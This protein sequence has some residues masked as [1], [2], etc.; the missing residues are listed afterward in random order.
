MTFGR[1]HVAYPLFH[2]KGSLGE[3]NTR[4]RLGN[5]ALIENDPVYGYIAL[6]ATESTA[7]TGS[8]INGPRNLAVVRVNKNDNSLDPALP[9]TLTVVSKGEQHTNRLKWLTHYSDS[10]N[11]HAERPKLIGIGSDRYI[12]LWEEWRNNGAYSDTF[13]GVYGMVIDARGNIIRAAALITRDHHLHRG[14]D[15]VFLNGRAA[16]VTG[17]GSERRLY[18]HLVDASLQYETIILP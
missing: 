16:W 14:D 8:V 17:N 2:I 12:V 5:V 6:F 9:D 11:L 7:A 15:A 18:L 1:D 10:S 13:N 3:N 4:T